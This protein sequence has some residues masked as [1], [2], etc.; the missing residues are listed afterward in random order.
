M[1]KRKLRP[2]IVYEEDPE[3]GAC[4]VF[5]HTAR[6][7]K[8]MGY[9]VLKDW[10]WVAEWID[11]RVRWLKKSDFLYEQ[12]A[13]KEKLENGTPHVIESPKSCPACGRWGFKLS[14]NGLCRPCALKRYQHEVG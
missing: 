8:K 11:A 5:A 9:E 10:N 1:N 14:K 7:A 3:Y 13:D 4:L 6:E 12:D 2:Y